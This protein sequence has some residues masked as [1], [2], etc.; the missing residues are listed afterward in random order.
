MHISMCLCGVVRQTSK[1]FR[2][3]WPTS[4]PGIQEKRACLDAP[5]RFGMHELE[6]CNP[7]APRVFQGGVR[8]I[9]LGKARL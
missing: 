6:L 5:E 2:I 1:V 8:Q 4:S 9:N 3:T 7:H